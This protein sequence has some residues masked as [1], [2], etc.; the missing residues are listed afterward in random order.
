MNDERRTQWL[1][2]VLDLCVLA[3]LVG[4][5]KSGHVAGNWQVG[6]LGP[7]R[8]YDFLTPL[9]RQYL[10]QQAVSRSEFSDLVQRLLQPKVNDD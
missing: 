8:K 2:G 9:R 10:E 3:S 7:G 5:E 1:R 4:G 6:S